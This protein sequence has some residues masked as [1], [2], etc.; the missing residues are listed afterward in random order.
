[1]TDRYF[2]A[3]LVKDGPFIGVRLFVGPPIV[4]GEELDRSPRLQV[5]V[6]D[7]TTSRAVLMLGDDDIPIEVDGATLRSIAS[8]TAAE[9]RYQ[10]A[11]QRWAI[12]NAPN[13]PKASPR[14]PVDFDTLLPF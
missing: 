5:M 6:A 7:E 9:W 13:H 2:R 4:D 8:I 1:M 3:R 11:H 10:V 12:E 14:K